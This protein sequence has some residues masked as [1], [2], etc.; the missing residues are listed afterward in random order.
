MAEHDELGAWTNV[1]VLAKALG[2]VFP[3]E[4]RFASMGACAA[5][6]LASNPSLLPSGA[7]PAAL[8]RYSYRAAATGFGLAAELA[9][10][11]RADGGSPAKHLPT[12]GAYA[13]ERANALGL[14]GGDGD[15]VL[16][17]TVGAL[18][19]A[20]EAAEAAEAEAQGVRKAYS[21]RCRPARLSWPRA[22]RPR[23]LREPAAAHARLV[24]RVPPPLERAVQR[25]GGGGDAAAARSHGAAE[26]RARRQRV[27]LGPDVD[28]RPRARVGRTGGRWARGGER[29]AQGGGCPDRRAL[30]E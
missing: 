20:V 8:D 12:K 1:V 4:P 27:R 17:A 21:R 10:L 23:R 24:G 16:G 22:C 26:A 3:D 5:L 29:G 19:G 14:A 30:S 11:P 18:R 15:E 25:A 2:S 6:E 9:A 28:G 7:P 13:F